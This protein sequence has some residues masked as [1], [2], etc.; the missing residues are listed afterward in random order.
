MTTILF[1]GDINL[2]DVV[3]PDAPFPK[4]IDVLSDADLRFANLECSFF[5]P[6]DALSEPADG[7]QARIALAEALKIAGF[8]VV[9]TANNGNYGPEA[10]LQ[11][12]ATLREHGIAEVGAGADLAAARKPAILEV[13]GQMVGLLQRT[14]VYWPLGHEATNHTPGVAVLPGH[15]S[16]MLQIH[17]TGHKVPPLN[18]PGNPPEIITWADPKALDQLRGDIEDLRAKCDIVI[19]S[20]HWG[21]KRD[22][23]AYMPE[24]A[25]AAID[26]GADAVIGHGPHFPMAVEIY[27]GKPV[28]YSL[29]S[30]CF[31]VGHSGKRSGNW[32]GMMARINF[33]GRKPAEVAFRWV[34]HDAENRTWFPDPAEEEANLKDVAA[35]SAVYGT[36]LS[37]DGNEIRVALD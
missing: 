20:H 36:R 32:S 12:S 24:I 19:A 25:H 7:L 6:K 4:V 16:Y 13:N 8:D 1:A 11:T 15:T 3:A 37:I 26:A 5:E 18:R 31:N 33:E 29:S 28:F 22:V 35:R 9:G 10:I 14:S 23:L 27:K 21:L 34:R 2:K 30:F 17:R